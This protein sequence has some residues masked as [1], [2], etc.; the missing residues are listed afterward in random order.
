MNGPRQ[1]R[2]QVGSIPLGGASATAYLPGKGRWGPKPIRRQ[3][4][5]VSANSAITTKTASVL[6]TVMAKMSR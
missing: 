6:I 3:V 5:P 4:R 2:S 1:A